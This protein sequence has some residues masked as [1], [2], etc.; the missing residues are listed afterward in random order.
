MA[1]FYVSLVDHVKRFAVINRGVASRQSRRSFMFGRLHTHGGTDDRQRHGRSGRFHE[2][3]RTGGTMALAGCVIVA[4]GSETLAAVMHQIPWLMTFVSWY[5]IRKFS[6]VPVGQ[7]PADPGVSIAR[8][9]TW[10]QEDDHAVGDVAKDT[11]N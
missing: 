11:G 5:A 3:N 2:D 9:E 6:R 8:S 7:S 4:G 10:S 1:P